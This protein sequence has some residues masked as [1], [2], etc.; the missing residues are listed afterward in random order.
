MTTHRITTTLKPLLRG[1]ENIIV[2]KDLKRVTV[3][4]GEGRVQ[5]QVEMLSP[6]E[7]TKEELL[8]RYDI[9]TKCSKWVYTFTDLGDEAVAVVLD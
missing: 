2:C 1:T 8:K 6:V 7:Y 5:Y 3:P 4:L 9:N